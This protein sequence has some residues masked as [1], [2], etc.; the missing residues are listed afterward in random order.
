MKRF[1]IAIVRGIIKLFSKLPLNWLYAF[2][3]MVSW[4]ICNVFHYRKSTVITNL[5]RSFP[6]KKYWEIDDIAKDFYR[7]LGDIFAEAIW[8]AGSGRERILE[9]K[10]CTITNPEVLSKFYDECGGALVLNTHC[11][12]WEILGGF[13]L[14]NYKEPFTFT[15]DD[16]YVVYKKLSNEVMNEVF[17]RN[18][19]NFC[20]DFPGMVESSNLLRLLINNKGKK[21]FYLCNSDQCPYVSQFPIG[22]FMNQDT[23]AMKGVVGFA[24][25]MSMPVLY[26]RMVHK[27]RGRYEITFIELCKNASEHKAEDIVRRYYDELEKEINETP[28]NWLWSHRRWK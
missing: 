24:V 27:E 12:N 22:K 28:Y 18:R 6:Q 2:F 14:Y 16:T 5:S 13:F 9:Q 15:M 17:K 19:I 10:I 11:G 4:L 20:P 21:A 7:H 8:F 1:Y 3:S 26:M 25:K 23:N